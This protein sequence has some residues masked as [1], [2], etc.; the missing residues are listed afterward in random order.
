MPRERRTNLSHTFVGLPP[1]VSTMLV[2]NLWRYEVNDV[3]KAVPK[4]V[5]KTDSGGTVRYDNLR[6]SIYS[7][8]IVD[9]D[10]TQESQH[11][12]Q[13]GDPNLFDSISYHVLPSAVVMLTATAGQ[14]GA[15]V[16]VDLTWKLPTNGV[17]G[18]YNIYVREGTTGNWSRELVIDNPRQFYGR[19]EP[20]SYNTTYYFKIISLNEDDRAGPWSNILSA[21]T[22]A[23]APADTTPPTSAGW[24]T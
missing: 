22:P 23:Q 14:E 17:D 11:H 15:N 16:Y 18:Y 19:I 9:F 24:I 20:L 2:D 12:V 8:L 6:D 4:N 3:W 21:T 1:G 13:I 5:Q 7:L 10:H